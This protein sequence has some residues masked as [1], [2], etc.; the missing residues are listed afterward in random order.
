MKARNKTLIIIKLSI[1]ALAGLLFS[2]PHV[3]TSAKAQTEFPEEPLWKLEAEQ[4]GRATYECSNCSKNF[5]QDQCPRNEN[6]AKV[7][8]RVGRLLNDETNSKRRAP[9]TQ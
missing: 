2:L 5:K 3:M 7:V 6:C 8:E 1:M 4:A 9:T